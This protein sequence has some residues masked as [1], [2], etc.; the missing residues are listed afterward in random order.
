MKT[1]SKWFCA[2]LAS[3]ALAA[4][5][6]DAPPKDS[7]RPA[8]QT[9][10]AKTTP[11]DAAQTAAAKPSDNAPA[12]TPANINNG[13]N[14][15]SD[16]VRMN[17]QD[18]SLETVLKYLSEAAGFIINVKPGTSIRG[19]VNIFSGQPVSKEEAVDLLDTALIQNGLAAIRTG[20]RITVVNR[21][22]AKTQH[23]PVFKEADPEKIPETDRI[24]TYIIPV[25]FVEVGQLIKDIQPLVS[26]QTSMTANESGNSVIVTDTQANI[27]RVAEVI[28]FV[29]SGAEDFT[30][31]Q[32]FQLKHADPTAMADLLT[33]LFPDD[34][35]TGNTQSPFAGRFGRFF[36]GGRGGAFGG[37]ANTGNTSGDSQNQR[38]KKRN[39][40]VAVA[41]ERTTS[42]IVSASRDLMDEIKDV[43]ENLDN[44]P[45]GVAVVQAFGIQNA[46]PDQVKQ[47]LTDIFNKNRQM[48]NKTSSTQTGALSSRATTQTQQQNQNSSSSRTGMNSGSRGGGPSFQ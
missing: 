35:K 10:E 2:I 4:Q 39:R 28:K 29:D 9:A 3:A 42:V 16:E 25:R 30:E 15:N 46:D 27:R 45:K 21:D 36:G 13:T 7:P 38:I 32:V 11:T 6:A 18:A 8:S 26:M 41:D 43:V 37:G 48:N 1:T 20:R 24:A 47:V 5:A 33:S 40:V 12:A 22:E 31:L 23:V 17:F 44:N 34:T 14:S 19:K